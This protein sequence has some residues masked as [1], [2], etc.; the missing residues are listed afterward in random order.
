MK[1]KTIDGLNLYYE[2]QGNLE[3]QETLVFLNGLTQ[4]TV[5]WFF[6][7][8]YFKEKYKK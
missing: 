3:S 6:M 5:A 4:S 8:P 7:L 1:C 2:I